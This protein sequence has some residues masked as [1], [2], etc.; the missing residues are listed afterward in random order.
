MDRLFDREHCQKFLL[1]VDVEYLTAR[2]KF[3]RFH[4]AHEGYAVLLEE[5][6]ELWQEVKK[7]TTYNNF[8]DE[9]VQIAAMAMAMSVE[10]RP[11]SIELS[12]LM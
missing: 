6:D 9:L 7:P 3:E 4:S 2:E 1:A 8:R 12:V 11:D 10:L 5:V